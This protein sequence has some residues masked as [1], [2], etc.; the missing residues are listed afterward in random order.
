MKVQKLI[1]SV[2][3]CMSLVDSDQWGAGGGGGFNVDITDG[4]NSIE[5]RIDRD[6]NLFDEEAPIGV[7]QYHG[8]WVGKQ[9]EAIKQICCQVIVYSLDTL[10]ILNLF[11]H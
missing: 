11:W 1:W 10:L 7:F 9:R 6:T 2:L 8:F 5:V 3:E 4:T